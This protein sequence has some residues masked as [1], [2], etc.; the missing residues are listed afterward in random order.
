MEHVEQISSGLTGLLVGFQTQFDELKRDIQGV[1][2]AQQTMQDSL[3]GLQ[4]LRA[5]AVAGFDQLRHQ[6]EAAVR[7]QSDRIDALR[8]GVDEILQGH[9]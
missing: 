1:K 4:V 7:S 6:T 2:A 8:N 5:S 3:D 9:K